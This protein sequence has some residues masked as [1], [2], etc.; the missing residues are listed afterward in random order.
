MALASLPLAGCW[1]QGCLTLQVGAA[2]ASHAATGPLPSP[3]IPGPPA[4]GRAHTALLHSPG[5]ETHLCVGMSQKYIFVKVH[6]TSLSF[7]WRG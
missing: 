4:P 5:P 6:R 3:S 2:S 7:L 1:M